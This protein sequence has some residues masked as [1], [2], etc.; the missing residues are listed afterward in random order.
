MVHGEQSFD[1][2]LSPFE[3]IP[4]PNER[5]NTTTQA[6]VTTDN[7]AASETKERVLERVERE[8]ETFR[9]GDLS[10]FQASSRVAKELEKWEGASDKDKG[11]AFDSYLAEINSFA[12]IQDEN[13]SVTREASP[14][15]GTTHISRAEQQSAKKRLRDEVE[16]LLDQVSGEELEG[17]EIERRVVRKRA[18]EEDMPWYNASSTSSRRNSCVE[19]CRILFQFSEDLSGVKALLR[20]ADRLPEGIPSSQWD[21]ILRG[22]SVDL[23]QILSSLHFVQLDEERKGRL[24][25][26]EV[27]FTVAES[28]RQVKTGSEWSSA[29]RRMSKAVVFLFPHRREELSEYAE[30]IEGLFSAKH[31]NAHSKVILYDQSVRNQVGGGQ[32]IL[33][34]D[35]Q[36]FNSLSEAILHAD[37]VEYRGSG[38][39]ASKGGKESE[40]GGP[41]KK[42]VC[43]R[44]NSKDGC[45]F[46][47]EECYYKQCQAHLQEMRKG[48]A[49][50]NFLHYGKAVAR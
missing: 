48:R 49:R 24:G 16:E 40:E 26:A 15:L 50:E 25:K 10:R 42:D 12:A 21:R 44:F 11:K 28:K 39:G 41:S 45:R 18:K 3:N 29:F 20:I 4:G 22:E 32:N 47:E 1:K 7:H 46:T 33:L 30:H 36:H 38:K 19:T 9:K 34:T 8:M 23:N 35:Y 37:G 13:R 17:E 6:A 2:S 31:T 14:P 27:V 5:E 43:R